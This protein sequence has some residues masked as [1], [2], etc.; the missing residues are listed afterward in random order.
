MIQIWFVVGDIETSSIS[1]KIFEIL[2]PI[3]LGTSHKKGI[4][5]DIRK[6]AVIVDE[7][8]DFRESFIVS[9]VLIIEPKSV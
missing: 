1:V 6:D 5:V 4:C 7:A 3:S 2:S 8:L 9:I